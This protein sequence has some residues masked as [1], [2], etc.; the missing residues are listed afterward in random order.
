MNARLQNAIA[1]LVLAASLGL[2][3]EDVV[4]DPQTLE[5][6]AARSPNHVTNEAPE[7][8][9]PTEEEE[10]PEEAPE[11]V[12]GVGV[13]WFKGVDNLP[14]AHPCHDSTT[15]IHAEMQAYDDPERVGDPFAYELTTLGEARENLGPDWVH[16][17]ARTVRGVRWTRDGQ[18]FMVASCNMGGVGYH[19]LSDVEHIKGEGLDMERAREA[20]FIIGQVGEASSTEW[21]S[22][23]WMRRSGAEQPWTVVE[24]KT[25][26][27]GDD[28]G[29]DPQYTAR[30]RIIAAEDSD[31]DR[32]PE[33]IATT[34]YD[35]RG[36]KDD[37]AWQAACPREESRYRCVGF[38]VSVHASEGGS[39]L[40]DRVVLRLDGRHALTQKAEKPAEMGDE[41]YEKLRSQLDAHRDEAVAKARAILREDGK[42]R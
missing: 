7:Q 28:E 36:W 42:L 35:R 15:V 9:S 27:S 22:L 11:E 17:G 31:G 20:E 21:G 40:S 25:L 10:E 13:S 16:F 6:A 4:H 30:A 39:T 34:F 26:R 1:T 29:N 32:Q 24:E 23:Y 19:S 8:E 12:E 2:G 37:K 18:E 38:G 33:V 3:C 41:V 5:P 14:E